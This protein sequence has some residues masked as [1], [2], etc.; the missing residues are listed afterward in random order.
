MDKETKKERL[1][2]GKLFSS[3]EE[4]CH[5]IGT[6][7]SPEP[8]LV[9]EPVLLRGLAAALAQL[10]RYTLPAVLNGAP[11]ADKQPRHDLRLLQ[12]IAALH[13]QLAELML[14][15]AGEPSTEATARV[16]PS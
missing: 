11:K 1:R 12:Q 3:L 14:S 7:T 13:E 15:A 2:Y 6:V 16:G 9:S 10:F 8:L 5:A 4:M